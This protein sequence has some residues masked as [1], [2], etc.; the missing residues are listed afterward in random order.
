MLYICS[1][2]GETTRFPLFLGPKM[3]KTTSKVVKT[4]SD[5]VK[6]TSDVVFTK[7]DVLTFST[8]FSAK[9]SDFGATMLIIVKTLHFLIFINFVKKCKKNLTIFLE[10]RVQR[11]EYNYRAEKIDGMYTANAVGATLCRP[12][13]RNGV[14]KSSTKNNC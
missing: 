8:D 10:Y 5:V 3:A 1:T 12:V 6:I 9:T 4:S 14:I 2:E 11:T 7:S 13:R